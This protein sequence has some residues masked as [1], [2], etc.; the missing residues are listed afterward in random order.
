MEEDGFRRQKNV[1]KLKK[2][3]EKYKKKYLEDLEEE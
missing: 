2:E 1:Y 3:K